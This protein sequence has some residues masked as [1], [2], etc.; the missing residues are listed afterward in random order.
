MNQKRTGVYLT[1]SE[2]RKNPDYVQ[3][4]RDGIGLDLA[5][6]S[7][8]GEPSSAVLDQSPFG[9]PTPSDECLRSLLAVQLDGGPDEPGEFAAAKSTVAPGTHTGGD[10]AL[11]EAV[12]ILRRAG[13]EI[14]F[15][16]HT[17]TGSS[18]MF[19]PSK[20]GVN[21]YLEALYIDCATRYGADGLDLTHARFPKCSV[22]EAMTA[23]ICD[24]C[25]REAAA[26]GYDMDEMKRS[27]NAARD[28]LGAVDA[29]LLAR[30][31]RDGT[32]PLDY[33]Q[34]L[35][36][37]RG[38]LDWFRFRCALVSDR[39]TR[40]HTAVHEAAGPDFIFGSDTYPASLAGFVGHDLSSWS[41]FSDFASPLVSHI[42][43][44]TGHAFVA[45]ARWLQQFNPGLGEADALQV[46]YQVTGY[47]GM[48]LPE[49]IAGYELEDPN[50]LAYVLP[51]EELILRDLRKARLVLPPD[52]PSYPIIHG[53]GWPR[54]AIDAIVSGAN[55]AGHDGIVWQGTDEL[56]SFEM[57]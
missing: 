39:L 2:V 10:A 26:R 53:K 1:T 52:I 5:V 30:I 54:T 4:L 42:A 21:D 15:C 48:G 45:W 38:V 33:L 44:F 40:F 12:D 37:D 43:S 41:R 24:D 56:V 36:M 46:V 27:L 9:G 19:C 6:L 23:C 13:L 55:A 8:D 25:R 20:P 57:K 49:T 47:A 17:W 29:G 18:L 14:W 34:L 7:Y 50:R 16:M 28:R 3:A 31:S 51:L 22:P 11:R 32:G 35:G